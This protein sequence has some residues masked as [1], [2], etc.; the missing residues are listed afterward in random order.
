MS[1]PEDRAQVEQNIEE[2]TREG[3]KFGKAA[4]AF[5][6]VSEAMLGLAE[7][8]SQ[9]LEAGEAV[10]DANQKLQDLV[11]QFVQEGDENAGEFW[12]MLGGM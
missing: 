2:L 3:V 7:H 5:G 8:L 6:E 1:N 9:T 4:V 10:E 12:K 11:E